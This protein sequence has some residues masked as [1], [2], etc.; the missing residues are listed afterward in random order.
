[1]KRNGVTKDVLWLNI[2]WMP[3][4][5]ILKDWN[6][7]DKIQELLLFFC[8]ILIFYSNFFFFPFFFLAHYRPVEPNKQSFI[9]NAAGKWI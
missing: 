8:K 6:L 2:L 7:N 5:F 9:Y 3:N 4:D 1:M